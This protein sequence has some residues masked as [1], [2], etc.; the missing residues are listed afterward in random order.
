MKRVIFVFVLFS[1]IIVSPIHSQTKKGRVIADK[2]PVFL[3]ANARSPLIEVLNKGN[4]LSLSVT[5]TDMG[6]FHVTFKSDKRDI[7]K[8]G[9]IE[10][11][12]VEVITEAEPILEEKNKEE[13]VPKKEYKVKE[14]E[15]KLEV[16]PQR[17][18]DKTKEPELQEKPQRSE[19]AYARLKRESLGLFG[20]TG[21]YSSKL[22][23][24]GDVWSGGF[25]ISGHGL[26]QVASGLYAGLWVAYNRWG[27]NS[28]YYIDIHAS[29][30]QLFPCLR[31]ELQKGGSVR[32]FIQVGA[33]LSIM[34]ATAWIIDLSATRIG[35]N[36]GIGARIL[37]SD[38]VG[39]E[40][41]AL[42]NLFSAVGGGTKSWFSLGLG[43]SFGL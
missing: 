14:P 34:K 33:G 2:A 39:I 31:Y 3:D 37:V 20:I 15:P 32:P 7:T 25:Y 41:I 29:N 18:E 8:S 22:N 40:A 17:A 43:L 13:V 19:Q 6:W 21:G 35:G 5:T 9:Y 16:K 27:T 1:L 42:Y 10:T 11:K 36:M 4:I 38:S 26:I 24:S 30:L 28:S 23:S 12:Y